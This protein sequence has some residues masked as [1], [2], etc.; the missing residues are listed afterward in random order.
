MHRPD[1]LA[2]DLSSE[3][4]AKPLP[5]LTNG[6][7]ADLDTTLVE[8]VLDVSKRQREPDVEHHRQADDLRARLELVKR[9]AFGHPARLA[10]RPARLK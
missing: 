9:G 10:T 7:V 5:P 4:R 6:L 1:P 3:H 8:E 2:P